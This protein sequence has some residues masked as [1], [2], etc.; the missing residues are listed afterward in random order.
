VSRWGSD[1]EP[2]LEEIGALDDEVR[3]ALT[4]E[5]GAGRPS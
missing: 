2:N 4:V 3:S 1:A 5:L